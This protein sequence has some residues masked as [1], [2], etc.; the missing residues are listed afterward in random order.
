[1]SRYKNV[2][3]DGKTRQEHRLVWEAAHGP[4]PDGYEI[5]HV[6]GNGHNNSLDNLVLLSRSEHTK[7]HA[8]L[9]KEN[10]DVVDATDPDVVQHRNF[11]KRYCDENKE[12]IRA[13]NAEYRARHKDRERARKKEYYE[14][15]REER[16]EYNRRYKEEHRDEV[17]VRSLE[18]SKKYYAEHREE[19]RERRKLRNASHSDEIAIR[20]AEYY[21]SHKEEIHAYQE[22]YRELNRPLM[23]AKAKLHYAKQKGASQTRIRELEAEVEA[24]RI[25][26][27]NAKKK[28]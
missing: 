6:D 1:M 15:H 20:N 4:I 21:A 10:R 12:K 14:T 3:V 11:T 9:R 16:L 28:Q 19:I 18:R 8:R 25:Q 7:L 27:E 2:L 5:H 22:R 26:V 13:K 23:C 17:R 24:A